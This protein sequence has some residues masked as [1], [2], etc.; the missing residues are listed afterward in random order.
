MGWCML[1]MTL[2]DSH[3][4]WEREA[5]RSVRSNLCNLQSWMI[6]TSNLLAQLQVCKQLTKLVGLQIAFTGN[7]RGMKMLT[8]DPCRGVQQVG[9]NSGR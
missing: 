9:Q 6:G 8:A 7:V 1:S 3:S 5:N 2:P 4:I